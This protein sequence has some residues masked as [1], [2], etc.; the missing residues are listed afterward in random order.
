MPAINHLQSAVRRS[1]C[2]SLRVA[3]RDDLRKFFGHLPVESLPGTGF[4]KACASGILCFRGTRSLRHLQ[5]TLPG[6]ADF[7]YGLRMS[8]TICL[9]TF[10]TT[11]LAAAL[12]TDAVRAADTAD[13]KQQRLFFESRIRPLLVR[14][15][16][17]CH[18]N[19][20]KKGGLQFVSR[21]SLLAG[22]ESGAAVV[23]HQP[24]QSL[25]IEAVRYESL[26]MPPAGKLPATDIRLLETWVRTGAFWPETD[27]PGRKAGDPFSEEDRSW[28]AFQPVRDPLPPGVRPF[29][30]HS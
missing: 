16:F 8:R 21:D 5:R 3:G 17:K 28:W 24:G 26:E 25:L 14:H 23:P 10:L 29:R 7:Q 6:E 30:R 2:R 1:L 12:S 13:V 19:G 20:Q 27:E 4:R 22:G 18:A 15:C 9:L 11:A